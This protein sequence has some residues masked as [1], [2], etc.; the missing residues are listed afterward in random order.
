MKISNDSAFSVLCNVE[1]FNS[2]NYE[3][4]KIV[5]GATLPAGTRIIMADKSEDAVISWYHC[6]AGGKTS[7]TLTDFT[8]MGT[9]TGFT[10]TK[11]DSIHA[12]YQFVVDYSRASNNLYTG[13][14]SVSVKTD[15][16]QGSPAYDYIDNLEGTA[17]VNH[18][19]TSFTMSNPTVTNLTASLNLTV[20]KPYTAS[21]WDGR[22]SAL[23][24]TPAN[25]S[26]LPADAHL[27]ITCG[28][29][30]TD[31]YRNECGS[32]IL[33]TGALASGTTSA[34]IALKSDMFGDEANSYTF[35]CSWYVSAT[36]WGSVPMSGVCIDTKEITFSKAEYRM[37]SIK[38]VSADDGKRV[39]LLGESI[40]V[41][42]SFANITPDLKV[43]ATMMYQTASGKYESFGLMRTITQQGV[44][45]LPLSAETHGNFSIL[46]E[47]EDSKGYTIVETPYYFIVQK[48]A[49]TQAQQI[50]E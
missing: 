12:V 6:N 8:A 24:M 16:I 13:I 43:K 11:L 30:T 45:E 17:S 7:V 26:M 2:A 31:Y 47:V 25:S 28:N 27:E 40:K 14:K 33:P 32:Y 42:I 9:S 4:P 38:I 20:T 15:K 48:P 36:E 22:A 3:T 46:V 21:K 1:Y 34:K 50:S 10:E 18:G 49:Q 23:V 41:D 29:L 35:N 39:Y 44:L 37:P 19:S 5:F